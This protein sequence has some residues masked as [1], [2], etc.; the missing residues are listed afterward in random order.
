MKLISG[1]LTRQPLWMK[2][3]LMLVFATL[4]VSVIAGEWVR[5]VETTHLERNLQ[6]ESRRAFSMLRT[7][8]L[9]AVITE[10][11]PQ[12]ET[13]ASMVASNFSEISAL[14]IENESGL[15]LAKWLHDTDPDP[16]S[17]IS[18][19]EEVVFE[20][21]R[22]GH[23]TM[24][25]NAAAARG[26]IEEHAT[27]I[28]HL[29]TAI[30][31]LL[32][33]AI[34][35]FLHF[36]VL[37]PIARINVRLL[38]LADGEVHKRS[39]V[40]ADSEL[41]RLEES[42]DALKEVLQLKKLREEEL[43][44]MQ[45]Q[46]RVVLHTV[47]DA[48]IMLK[49][50]GEIALTNQMVEKIWGYDAEELIGTN[51]S[52]LIQEPL[53]QKAVERKNLDSWIELDGIS[54]C[55]NVLPLE[56]H[57]SQ[58]RLGE[59]RYFVCAIRDITTRRR[60]REALERQ[61][62]L[63][64]AVFNSAPDT[65]VLADTNLNITMCNPE[66]TT[67]FGYDT[68]EVLGRNSVILY[69]EGGEFEKHKLA[70]FDPRTQAEHTPY[71]VRYRRKDGTTFHGETVSTLL[72]DADGK[73]LGH[74]GLIRDV[75]LRRQA[76]L[77]LRRAKEQ[78][79]SANQIKS[80]F[81]S[82]VSHEIRTPMNAALGMLTLLYDT[83]LS[84]D[85]R[86]YV[87]TAQ[88]SGKILLTL[89]N[90]ILDISK[91][92]AGK[93][94]LESTALY[95]SDVV[96]SVVDLLY[97]RAHEKEIELFVQIPPDVP[98]ALRGDPGR[99]R[100]VLLNL[101]GNA[102]KF[103]EHGSVTVRAELDSE[104]DDQAKVQF[105]VLDTGIGIS[106][107]NQQ[108][109]FSEFVQLDGSYSRK[110]GGSG[111]GLAISKRLVEMMGGSIDVHSRVGEGSEFRFW[112]PLD[113]QPHAANGDNRLLG[114]L[115][116]VRV[117]AVCD[118]H[119]VRQSWLRV[120]FAWG[121]KVETVAD[122]CGAL[123]RLM[124]PERD[125]GD[126][127]VVVAV[128]SLSGLPLEDFASTVTS[129]RLNKVPKFVGVLRPGRDVAGRQ[130]SLEAKYDHL[131]IN[132]GSQSSL[133]S[134]IATVLGRLPEASTSEKLEPN[135]SH[136]VETTRSAARILVAEDSIANQIVV[137]GMLKGA[138]YHITTVSNGFEAADAVRNIPFD[139]VLMDVQMPEMNGFEATQAIRALSQSDYPGCHLSAIQLPIIAM[140]ANAMRGDREK[141]LAAGMSDYL[142][143]PIFKEDLLSMV[144]RWLDATAHC[145]Q[146]SVGAAPNL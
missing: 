93:L 105:S 76:D 104:T 54:K 141:C 70:R 136:R 37:R 12:L 132:P 62:T 40:N 137:D 83:T 71:V 50:D 100:Q 88:G 92:E 122:T 131:Y 24:S 35:L 111:L 143:K 86:S 13:V 115:D 84:K 113:K 32:S 34:L 68:E 33:I 80:E 139:L 4:L 116:G 107:T 8:I 29:S 10:D 89:L 7:A 103:T 25:M 135:P 79:E 63:F 73:V 142:S 57:V 112:L 99:L 87:E 23:I 52:T 5:R 39:I 94:E 44:E 51:I 49:P 133:I 102:I 126:Y 130:Q 59:E 22:F 124:Q 67:N 120:L 36:L 61:K 108:R 145:D 96:E 114:A 106:E 97:T 146:P 9:E 58:A 14:T 144:I 28:R 56:L 17:L 1:L 91:I 81:L 46:L 129:Q 18:F 125:G 134:G 90:D 117:L 98:N 110:Y 31:V 95:P 119:A 55:G 77:E 109:L 30:V 60:E 138:G 123:E 101:V 65:L 69:E 26:R 6:Q 85:Q 20:G 82:V 42:V 3:I 43:V 64:E 11:R 16:D 27:R 78:A 72:R 15:V 41:G 127:D 118:S 2:I 48:V 47:G 38:Q 19:T 75:T 66:L 53:L 140:T 45:S 128:D 121:V 21:E 74:L